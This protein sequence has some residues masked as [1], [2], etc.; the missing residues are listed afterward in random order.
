MGRYTEEERLR[1]RN[2]PLTPTPEFTGGQALSVLL[3]LLMVAGGGAWL[4]NKVVLAPRAAERAEV[5]ARE[6]YKNSPEGK[7]EAR[8]AQIQRG[9]GFRGE[10]KALTGLIKADMDDPSSF[11]VANCV[12]VDMDDHVVVIEEFRGRNAYGM[13]QLFSV[14]AKCDVDGNVIEVMNVKRMR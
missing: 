12:W 9:F 8:K 14:K 1:R 5:A 11:E 10:H 4:Y 6:A 3:M 2:T 7:K 13:M